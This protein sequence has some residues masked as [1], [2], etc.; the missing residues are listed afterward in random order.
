VANDA[1]AGGSQG[2]ATQSLGPAWQPDRGIYD[3]LGRLSRSATFALILSPVGLI[4]ISVTRLLIVADYNPVTASAIASSGGYVDT[5]LGSIIPLLPVLA[6]YIALI[7]LFFNRTILAILVFAATAFVSPIEINRV[8]AAGLAG[9]D[10]HLI[11]HSNFFII[12]VLIF[13][14]VAFVLLL[15]FE[16]MTLGFT[17]SFKTV[18]T[19]VCI[20]LIPF[21]ARLYPLPLNSE[22]YAEQVRQPWLPPETIMLNSGQKF[23]GYVLDDDGSWLVVLRNDSR[24]VN[25]YPGADVTSRKVCRIGPKQPTEPLITFFPAG[26]HAPTHTPP[27]EASSMHHPGPAITPKNHPS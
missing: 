7:L 16:F 3:V 5:L 9:K 8:S 19:I 27:C 12:I 4:F 18:T 26:L 23:T 11:I 24:T 2:E 13:L 1:Q 17:V 6:P 22:F 10:W 14:A 25:Y 15:S 20:A 21:V